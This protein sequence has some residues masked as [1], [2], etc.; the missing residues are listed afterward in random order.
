MDILQAGPESAA[1]LI[2]APAPLSRAQRAHSRLSWGDRL[3]RNARA[4]D[5]SQVTIKWFGIPARFATLLALTAVE[6][7]PDFSYTREVS[8]MIH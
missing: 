4:E 8:E 7:S 2:I 6:H 1:P 5:A 3:A